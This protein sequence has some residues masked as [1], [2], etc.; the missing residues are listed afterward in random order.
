[1]QIMK[2]EKTLLNVYNRK[3]SI[4]YHTTMANTSRRVFSGFYSLKSEN[5]KYCITSMDVLIVFG[6]SQASPSSFKCIG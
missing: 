6:I 3:R 5:S 2:D 4:H 1:M